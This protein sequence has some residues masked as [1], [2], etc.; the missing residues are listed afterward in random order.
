[1]KS[2]AAMSGLL[3]AFGLLAG[4]SD[5]QAN[6]AAAPANEAAAQANEAAAPASEAGNEATPAVEPAN[7]T[8]AT[9]AEAPGWAGSY[10]GTFEGNNARGTLEI[11]Q[12]ANGRLNV[13]LGIGAP[14]CAGG[15]TYRDVAAPAGDTLV[16][17]RPAGEGE[18]CKLTLKRK[19]GTIDIAEEDCNAHGFECSFNGTVKR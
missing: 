18:Q 4:C 2:F 19:G 6:E 1:M 3:L 16:L 7:Q 8:S 13:D 5:R 10:D 15:V 12:T 11:V 14:G 17:T 9:A